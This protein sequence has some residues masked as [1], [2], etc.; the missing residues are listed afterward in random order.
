MRGQVKSILSA[1]KASRTGGRTGENGNSEVAGILAMCCAMILHA[2][3]RHVSQVPFLEIAPRVALA[4]G[5]VSQA[6]AKLYC[7]SSRSICFS[8]KG[9]SAAK[10]NTARQNP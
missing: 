4:K 10:E 9:W 5:V 6:G 3:L 8:F 7:P 2:S 1:A